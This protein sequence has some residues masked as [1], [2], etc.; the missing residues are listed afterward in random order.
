MSCSHSTHIGRSVPSV[1]RIEPVFLYEAPWRFGAALA[2][3]CAAYALGR[4]DAA[5]CPLA[6]LG[7]PEGA[8]GDALAP[9]KPRTSTDDPPKV[10]VDLTDPPAASSTSRRGTGTPTRMPRTGSSKLVMSLILLGHSTYTNKEF[11]DARRRAAAPRLNS[12]RAAA[13]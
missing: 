5:A 9:K 6:H 10:T 11:T 8:D 3:V 1:T 4:R 7:A 13:R 2:V 12:S